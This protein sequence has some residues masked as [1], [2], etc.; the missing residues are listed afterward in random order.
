MKKTL[1]FLTAIAL[2]ASACGGGSSCAAIVDDGVELFQDVIDELD[3][4]TLADIQEDPF[5]NDDFDRRSDDLER[6][7]AEAGC[8]DEELTELFSERIGD[9][10]A[11]SDNPAGQA[12]ISALTSAASSGSLDFGG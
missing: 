4:L 3:G 10:S 8:T 1:L 5:S 11:G 7:T 6:R 2:I 12:L 9:L